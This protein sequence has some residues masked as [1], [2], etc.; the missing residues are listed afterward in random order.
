[1]NNISLCDKY[2]PKKITELFL[3]PKNNRKN[4]RIWNECCSSY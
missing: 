4:Y 1:M 2:K 3:S